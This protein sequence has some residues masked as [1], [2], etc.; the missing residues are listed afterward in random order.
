M[1]VFPFISC[2]LH[3]SI[4]DISDFPI[5]SLQGKKMKKMVENQGLI[6]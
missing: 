6:K 5:F 2:F 4:S 3:F 1:T